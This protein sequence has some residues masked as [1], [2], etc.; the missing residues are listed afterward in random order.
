[1]FQ[2]PRSG[3]WT[4]REATAVPAHETGVSSAGCRDRPGSLEDNGLGIAAGDREKIFGVLTRLNGAY[5]GS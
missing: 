5:E 1:V 2:P 3:I 4:G